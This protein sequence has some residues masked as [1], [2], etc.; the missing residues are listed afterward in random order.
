[1]HIPRRIQFDSVTVCNIC[2]VCCGC[3]YIWN[4]KWALMVISSS[5]YSCLERL[6]LFGFCQLDNVFCFD[7]F[8]IL[9]SC[10]RWPV[11]STSYIHSHSL[12]PAHAL[13]RRSY[14]KHCAVFHVRWFWLLQGVILFKMIWSCRTPL[15]DYAKWVMWFVWHHSD[16]PP[17]LSH[18]YTTPI[19]PDYSM[20]K[21]SDNIVPPCG[22]YLIIFLLGTGCK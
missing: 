17:L 13:G 15:S 7:F 8:R 9:K 14:A 12:P 18:R 3:A 16:C 20:P 5:S 21:I 6:F 2:L 1:M 22:T 11:C 4:E 10:S 19:L